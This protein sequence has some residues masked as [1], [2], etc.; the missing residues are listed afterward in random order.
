MYFIQP[1]PCISDSNGYVGVT[2]A[3]LKKRLSSHFSARSK[4]VGLRNAFAKHG[5]ENFTI[6]VLQYGVPAEL[7]PMME[8]MWIAEFD[9]HKHGYNC[10]KGGETNPMDDA[11][12][13][14]KHKEIMS[15]PDFIQR[16]LERR[17][18]TFATEEFKDRKRKAH[19]ASWDKGGEERKEKLSESLKASWQTRDR[20]ATSNFH[21]NEWAKADVRLHRIERMKEANQKPERKA[22]KSCVTSNRWKDP[23]YR[24]KRD[25]TIVRKAEAKFALMSPE[26]AIVAR[27]K[28]E[29]GREASR[30]YEAKRQRRG[31]WQERT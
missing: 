28:W 3:S 26:D 11:D 17:L 2:I 22:T 5:R 29:K 23:E 6:V 15:N 9:T 18:V 4:C 16:T 25:A 20:E 21:K 24:R 1:K 30:R 10:T 8:V 7:L 12:V 27:I 14:K 31:A 13:R 19:Q